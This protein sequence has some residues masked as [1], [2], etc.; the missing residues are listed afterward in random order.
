MSNVDVKRVEGQ[1]M[2]VN[3]YLVR[4]PSGVVV[5]DGQ[6]TVSDAGRVRQ[7]V[8]A[9]G[10]Q[11]AGVLVT[12]AHPDHYAG[13]GHL[14]DGADVPIVA[15]ERVDEIIRRDDAIKDGIVG[16]MMGAEWPA[17]RVFP[18]QT[19]AND[20][21]VELA[22]L[23][24]HVRDLGPGESPADSLW[25]VDEHAMFAG[26][27]SYHQMHSYLADGYYQEW[28]ATIGRL[29]E[30]LPADVTLFVGHGEPG[31]L[32]LLASQRRYIETFTAA[33][34]DH[35]DMDEDGMKAVVVAHMRQLVPS[36]RLQFL[37]ELSI[38]PVAA[39]L[40]NRQQSGG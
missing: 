24:F 21:T 10:G 22:G 16:P 33:V 36:E 7:A 20:G 25:W 3:S 12:H 14:L 27:V 29:E 23:S 32:E 5:V 34:G 9:T 8:E 4:G 2:T 13:I 15:T 11:L 28:L 39:S 35:L 18:N 1:V 38:A 6:L 26:D 40:R 19:V 37:M 30:E 17:H 31:G